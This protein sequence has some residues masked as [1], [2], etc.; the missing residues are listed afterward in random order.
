MASSA[1]ADPGDILRSLAGQPTRASRNVVLR[2]LTDREFA[3]R[4]VR[5]ALGLSTPS[6]TEDRRVL[7]QVIFPYYVARFDMRS[8]LFVGCDWYTRHYEKA[9]FRG[10][11]YWT[12]EPSERARRFGSRRQH[13]AAPWERLDAYFPECYFDLII[14]NGV[15]GFGLNTQEQCEAAF[16]HSHSRLRDGGHL[17]LG[18][19]DV[20]E[21]TP[22]PLEE[23]ASLRR[24]RPWT[25]PGFSSSRYVTDT[26]HRHVYDFYVK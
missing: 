18:W 22:V 17:L 25:F 11:N 12:I 7:E 21:T 3:V 9:F 16:A 23:I 20:P 4:A 13:V 14:A 8:V 15:Y 26:P 1:S 19:N 24:F 5:Y 10:R 6:R 2:L